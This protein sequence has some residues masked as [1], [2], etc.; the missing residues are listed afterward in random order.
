MPWKVGHSAR[1]RERNVVEVRGFP[2][3]AFRATNAGTVVSAHDHD[4][5]GEWD[6]E[7][8]VVDAL[9]S[10]G[11]SGSPVLAV[12]CATGEYELVGIYHA[13]YTEGSA[14]NV[15]IGID[16][17]R[18][19]MTTLKRASRDRSD[20]LSSFDQKSRQTIADEVDAEHEFFFPFGPQI[21]VVR[22]GANSALLLVLFG[23]E[24]PISMDPI[25]VL[26]DLAPTPDAPEGALGHVW[27]GSAQGLKA[28]DKTSLDAE[29][30]AQAS[31]LLDALRA[32]AV[33]HATYQAARQVDVGSRQSADDLHRLRKMLAR[34]AAARVDLLQNLGEVAERL[35]PQLGER[36]ETLADV[37]PVVPRNAFPQP[38]V[39]APL[40]SAPTSTVPLN[41]DQLTK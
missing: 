23:R 18:D 20:A 38:A 15:V 5:D 12:S 30:Q 35:A 41:G 33:A 17:V 22:P 3:G 8:F 14:L 4:D 25:L 29:G 31:R 2:L 27:F 10:S 28:Y 13:G 40:A 32:N 11:N 36:G 6:H 24:F 21:A 26:E 19:L 9:L 39:R 16:Q 34:T 1:L 37:A 7:D